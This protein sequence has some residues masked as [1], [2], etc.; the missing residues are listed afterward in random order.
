MPAPSIQALYDFETQIET[1]W[2]TAFAEKFTELDITC[3]VGKSRDRD[4]ETTPRVEISLSLGGPLTQRTT[5]GQAS[6]KQVPNAFTGTLTVS[7]VTTR[8]TNSDDHGPIRGVVRYLLSG[9]NQVVGISK[10]PYLQVLDMEPAGSAPSVNEEKNL[11][12]TDM[13]YAITFAI[14]NDAWP[15]TA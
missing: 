12:S 2:A 13:A 1:A 6:P 10:L 7:V 14:R 8:E 5:A 11:D 9:A 15:A 3:A 4:I